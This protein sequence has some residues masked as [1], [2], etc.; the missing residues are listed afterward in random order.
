MNRWRSGYVIGSL[1]VERQ[2]SFPIMYHWRNEISNEN[3][4]VGFTAAEWPKVE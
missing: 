3:S 2:L 1:D 4:V